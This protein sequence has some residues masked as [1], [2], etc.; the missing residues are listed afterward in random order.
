MVVDAGPNVADDWIADRIEAHDIVV[1]QDIPLA[2][3]CLEKGRWRSAIRGRAFTPDS[4]GMALAQRSI[5]E[6]LR[7]IGETTRGP[8]PL[9]GRRP[10]RFLSALD[11][12]VNR[13]KRARRRSAISVGARRRPGGRTAQWEAPR[14]CGE[15][16]SRRAPDDGVSAA[17]GDP[18]RIHT[19]FEIAYDCPEPVPM[20]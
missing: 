11:E 19:G 6:H 3:R 17:T 8:P 2:S 7:S 13:A 12:A 16:S 10:L 9:P 14:P 18:M 1:T 15:G 5:G 4:I 20:L